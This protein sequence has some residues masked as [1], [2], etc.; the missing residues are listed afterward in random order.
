MVYNSI[1]RLIEAVRKNDVEKFLRYIQPYLPDD[2]KEVGEKLIRESFSEYPIKTTMDSKDEIQELKDNLDT[3]YMSYLS[4]VSL[5]KSK[6]YDLKKETE[7]D[8]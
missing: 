7:A 5:W 4:Q 3:L 1:L 6:Y 2:E 8:F